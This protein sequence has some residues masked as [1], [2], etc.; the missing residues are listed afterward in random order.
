M[1]PYCS[2]MR[3]Y[4]NKCAHLRHNYAASRKI[5]F[6]VSLIASYT[7]SPRER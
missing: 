4:Q 1:M 2:Y 6:S 5:Y 7:L 3:Y